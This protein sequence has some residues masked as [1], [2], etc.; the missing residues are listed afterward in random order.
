MAISDFLTKPVPKPGEHPQE[1]LPGHKARVKVRF[2]AA[3]DKWAYQQMRDQ[4]KD[5]WEAKRNEPEGKNLY[6]Y[7]V[8]VEGMQGRADFPRWHCLGEG[9]ANL[10]RRRILSGQSTLRAQRSRHADSEVEAEC[11]C[12]D[13]YENTRHFL[14]QCSLHEDRR[15]EFAVRLIVDA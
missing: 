15:A 8:V 14:L 2:D 13:G 3:V 9:K 1:T 5:H 11:S 6:N 12:R 10:V 7:E 4:L